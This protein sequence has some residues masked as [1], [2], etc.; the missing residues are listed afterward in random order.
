MLPLAV[1]V[2]LLLLIAGIPA[3]YASWRGRSLRRLADDGLLPDRLQ[4]E[5]HRNTFVTV[6]SVSAQL[7]LGGWHGLWTIPLMAGLLLAADF[8]LRR[9]LFGETWTLRQYLTFWARWLLA[10]GGFWILLSVSPSVIWHSGEF[11]PFVA[12]TAA[13]LLVL[14][15]ARFDRVF[16]ALLRAKRLTDATL[17]EAFRPVVERASAP[18]PKIWTADVT[19]GNVATAVA[20][21]RT[22][23][24]SV[25]FLQPL[26][27]RFPL[28]EIVAVFAHEV[29]HRSNSPLSGCASSAASPFSRLRSLSCCLS[30][31]L[32]SLPHMPAS[33]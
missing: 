24:G 17:V 7:A 26:L 21:P 23:Q 28:E 10:F 27:D 30:L 18:A 20:L 15:N 32:A 13:A 22:D 1:S 3:A 19:G 5:R 29:G 31:P 12:A 14:W 4:A 33:G 9:Q 16:L 8:P 2:A 11:A 6:F 25:L